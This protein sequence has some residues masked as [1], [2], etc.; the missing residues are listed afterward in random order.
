MTKPTMALAELAEK[1][2]D[3][4]LLRE[5]IQYVAQRMMEMDVEG[6]CGAAYGERSPERANSRNGYRDRLWETRAGSVDLE[7]PEAALGEL[8]PRLPGAASDGREGPGR[9][10]PGSLRPGR[11][12]PLGRRAGEGHGHERDQQEPGLA[13]VRR[14]RRAGRGVPQSPDRGRLAV[15]VDRRDLREDAR[16]RQDRLGGRDNRRRR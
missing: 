15:P 14:D 4:D 16:G 1:G 7:D 13:A 3:A 10:D 5:M 2:P 12:D 8:L 9:G 6:R 11:V